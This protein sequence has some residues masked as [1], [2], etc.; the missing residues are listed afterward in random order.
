MSD[1][2]EQALNTY[3]QLKRAGGGIAI[4]PSSDSSGRGGTCGYFVF[5]VGP[6]GEV[7]KT[8]V[9]PDSPWYR[10]GQKV[11]FGPDGPLTWHQR[12]AGALADAQRWVAETF[13]E[14]GPWVRN[15]MG[16]YL[17][18]RIHKAHPLRPIKRYRTP[19]AESR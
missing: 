19:R 15:R 4:M 9:G 8:D 2:F 6:K 3:D 11:F 18:E 5:R 7:I 14:A 17:P 13:H 1:V 10:H 16:D 12:Q